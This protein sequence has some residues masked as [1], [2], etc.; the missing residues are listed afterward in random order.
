MPSERLTV[1]T[2][3]AIAQIPAAAWDACANP[4]GMSAEAMGGDRFNPFLCHAFL[5]ALE[6]SG[7]VGGRSGWTP[8][9]VLVEDADKR[10][11]ACA[12]A[13]VKA[14]SQGEYVFDH[15]WAEA[16]S[17]VGGRYYP[18]LQV[19]VP[20]TPVPGRRLL[21]AADAPPAAEGALIAGLRAVREAIKASSIHITF[22]SEGES[23]RWSGEGWLART[24]EQFHFFNDGYA[25]FDGF[26][27]ALSSRKRKA[28][29][30]ERRD[31]LGGDLRVEHVTGAALAKAHWDAFFQ[32]YMDT[33]SRKWGH[34]YLNRKFFDLVGASIPERIALFIA[35]RGDAPIAGALNFIGDDA[36]YGRYWGAQ[37]Q[38]PFLHFELCYYQAIDFALARGLSRVEAGAQGEHKLLR[39]YRAVATHSLHELADR[40]LSVAVEEYLVRERAA[41]ENAIAESVDALPFRNEN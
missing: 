32:F 18:K 41:V 13:Y 1:R 12:P 5:D 28:I 20:F 26:L 22:A 14:H 2:I 21:T 17:R 38:R 10:L 36:L 16:Y 35:Y 15:G 11:V 23:R 24:G 31:A 33:G 19:A 29:K 4:K 6:R 9:H 3:D 25:D 27:A 34:P 37:E 40:R 30:R 8:I 7:S 39:G